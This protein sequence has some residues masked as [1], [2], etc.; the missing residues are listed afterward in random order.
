MKEHHGSL[1]R[2]PHPP[3]DLPGRAPCPPRT[4]TST[5]HW[6]LEPV[7]GDEGL[8]TPSLARSHTA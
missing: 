5:L 7:T 4:L 6:Q 3:T 2:P 8:C 1:H